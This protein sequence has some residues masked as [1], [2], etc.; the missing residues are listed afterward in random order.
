MDRWIGGWMD[1]EWVDGWMSGWMD[2]TYQNPSYSQKELYP[3]TYPLTKCL[4]SAQAWDQS[5]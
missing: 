4:P 3:R 5:W 2:E 1:G